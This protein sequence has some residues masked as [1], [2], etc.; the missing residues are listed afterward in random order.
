MTKHE[1]RLLILLAA[2]Q[3]T[4]IVDFMILMP[5]GPQL[6]RVLEIGT[7]EFGLLVS[8]YTFAAGVSGFVG[9][10]WLD[11]V[12][13]RKALLLSFG[14]FLLGN[15]LCAVA[16]DYTQLLLGRLVS[17]AFG[18]VMGALVFAVIG[19]V[20][21]PERRGRATG[22][23][24]ASFSMAS[25]AGV[26]LSMWMATHW[27][28]RSP[29]WLLSG[30][31]VLLLVGLVLWM[32]HIQIFRQAGESGWSKIVE[33]VKAPRRL[34][35]LLLTGTLILGQFS[36]I[37]FIAPY[38]V[39]NVGLAE[40]HLPWLYFLG[41]AA[42]LW[43]SQWIGRWTDRFGAIRMMTL[44]ALASAFP[45]LALT[46]MPSIP[47]PWPFVITTIFMVLIS[48]RMIPS[49]TVVNSTVEPRLRGTFLSLNGSVQQGAAALASMLSAFW[50]YQNPQG[51][52]EG[53]GWIGVFAVAL[54]GVSVWAA[55]QISQGHPNKDLADQ[56]HSPKQD[57]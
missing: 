56:S 9:M 5:L 50:I 16:G 53:Y 52:L 32:P 43:T 55:R 24:M 10:F 54:I 3:F 2:L 20:I 41:G 31:S 6:M 40:S 8:L 27:G 11:L 42:T 30:L 44:L 19:D 14:G 51:K 15:V 57:T 46:W 37:P 38:L 21:A 12:S 17:G 48:G 4:H 35:A 36:V 13:R 29:F 33:V 47:L 39:S 25:V 18:G 34:W 49:M 7:G 1:I 26:P 28:W 23:V 45:L 22:M